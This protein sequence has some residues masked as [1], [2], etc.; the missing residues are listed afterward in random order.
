MKSIVRLAVAAAAGLLPMTAHAQQPKLIQGGE[1]EGV[2]TRFYSEAYV[3]AAGK[4]DCA[5]EAELE[6]GMCFDDAIGFLQLTGVSSVLVM[7]STMM[8][9]SVSPMALAISGSVFELTANADGIE[10]E[11]LEKSELRI[12]SRCGRIQGEAVRH[13]WGGDTRVRTLLSSATVVCDGGIPSNVRG[14]PEP[15]QTFPAQ[16]PV[17]GSKAKFG[18]PSVP[19]SE[20]PMAQPV[21]FIYEFYGD[22]TLLVYPE[23]C[24]PEDRLF[25]GA[26]FSQVKSYMQQN[27]ITDL[28]VIATDGNYN[29]GSQLAFGNGPAD[30]IKVLTNRN[31]DGWKARHSPT[32]DSGVRYPNG[33]QTIRSQQESGVI[34]VS[35]G[36]AQFYKWM[37]CPRLNI[38]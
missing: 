28:N 33:C 4:P 38:R 29:V 26:C 14:V 8:S 10:V 16:M 2:F 22:Q 23:G 12:S 18:G 36:V 21:V 31:Y 27:G 9:D 3:V 1:D 35:P 30:V 11:R 24:I 20:A 32:F 15:S 19:Y 5:P 37:Q 13:Q 7:G 6:P 17:A 34:I 25:N